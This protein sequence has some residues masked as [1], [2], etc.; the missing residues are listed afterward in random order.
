[1]ALRL[2]QNMPGLWSH[3][4][5]QSGHS[6][7][8]REKWRT[9]KMA[10]HFNRLLLER[11]LRNSSKPSPEEMQPVDSKAGEVIIFNNKRFHDVEPW[12][13][14]QNREIYIIRCFP[15]FDIGLTPPTE[16]LNGARCNR[17]L[18][19]PGVPGIKGLSSMDELPPFVP[20]PA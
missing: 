20:I 3:R 5:L 10:Q 9:E 7:I 13:L 6:F 15:L 14:S 2:F 8:C 1:M 12:K 4:L 19:S 18:L 17:F 11:S 16:F